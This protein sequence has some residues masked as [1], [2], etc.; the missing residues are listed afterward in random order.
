MY[1]NLFVYIINI[2]T[3]VVV[4]VVVIRLIASFSAHP[5][6]LHSVWW[7]PVALGCKWQ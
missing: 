4:V 6:E 1:N 7:L 3:I 2:I 5:S